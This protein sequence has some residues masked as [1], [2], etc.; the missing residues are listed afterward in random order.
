MPRK[1]RI[2]ELLVEYR[3]PFAIVMEPQKAF[4]CIVMR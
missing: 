2:E 4:T 3:M 1:P